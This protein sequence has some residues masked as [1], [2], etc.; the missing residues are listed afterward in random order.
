MEKDRVSRR[1]LA[2]DFFEP[3][4]RLGDALAVGPG[5]IAGGDVV[6]PSHFVRALQNLETAVLPRRRIDRD[7]DAAE[8]G[9]E[10]AVLIPVAVILMPG[11]GPA[12]AGV[13]QDHLR[14]VMI[15]LAANELL[16]RID[17]APATSHHAVDPVAGMIPEGKADLVSLSVVTRHRRMIESVV[18][19]RRF[20]EESDFLGG[21]E[22]AFDEVSVPVIARQF[23][24]IEDSI[25]GS[26][27]AEKSGIV[28][29]ALP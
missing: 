13:F 26:S 27:M 22:A 20:T 14:V 15:D 10:E 16:D 8:I 24:L 19:P 6:D 4:L 11:P 5:L 7:H 3:L 2:V 21:K 1:H 18:G 12:D 29:D 28:N 17:D 9:K 25:H 23:I